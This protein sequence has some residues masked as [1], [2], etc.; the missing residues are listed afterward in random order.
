MCTRVQILFYSSWNRPQC[1]LSVAAFGRN[2]WDQIEQRPG[3]ANTELVWKQPQI[4]SL[5]AGEKALKTQKS[6]MWGSLT[7]SKCTWTCNPI[8]VCSCMS[9][10]YSRE[11]RVK[12]RFFLK[13]EWSPPVPCTS[14]LIWQLC[15]RR[16]FF[17]MYR[18]RQKGAVVQWFLR[19]RRRW[20]D[21]LDSLSDTSS[22]T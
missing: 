4:I 19:E 9:F 18:Q 20:L 13:K 11:V 22:F 6:R 12:Q 10:I 7:L 15:Y 3:D 14:F 2:C 16:I 5:Q 1:V 17:L 21:G 8:H